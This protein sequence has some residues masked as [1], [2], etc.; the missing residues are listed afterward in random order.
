MMVVV[1]YDT[2]QL[3]LL[4]SV[5]WEMSTGQSVMML[6]SWGVKAWWLIT[7]VDKRVAGR[8]DPM[9]KCYSDL[10]LLLHGSLGRYDDCHAM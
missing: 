7:L 3:S 2:G 1:T 6:C 5:G 8:C 10:R 9:I 4:P